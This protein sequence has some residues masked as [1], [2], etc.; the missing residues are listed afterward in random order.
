[1]RK[2]VQLSV[3][4]R[5]WCN[6]I[7][8]VDDVEFC[9]WTWFRHTCGMC[10]KKTQNKLYI[11]ETIPHTHYFCEACLIAKAKKTGHAVTLQRIVSDYAN[12]VIRKKMFK[13]KK[14][15]FRKSDIFTAEGVAYD[16]SL[17][18]FNNGTLYKGKDRVR[19]T[20]RK[21]V[22]MKLLGETIYPKQKV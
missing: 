2:F 17:I 8:T 5:D 6:S 18:L 16:H 15:A 12:Y 4:N 14:V 20:E 13:A 21:N 7:V 3:I 19:V 22:V 10:K 11:Y 1:M 9:E